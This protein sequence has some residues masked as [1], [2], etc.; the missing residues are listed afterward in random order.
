M[1]CWWY[2]AYIH[3]IHQFTCYFVM[4]HGIKLLEEFIACGILQ[5][6]LE[7]ASFK[8]IIWPRSIHGSSSYCV[9]FSS[10]L[11]MVISYVCIACLFELIIQFKPSS[12]MA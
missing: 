10:Y 9:E 1:H 3:L 12:E 6:T 11:K 8:N 2:D 7:K 4:H 5:S